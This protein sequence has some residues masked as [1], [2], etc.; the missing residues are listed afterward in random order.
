M[1][2]WKKGAKE[3]TVGINY[4]DKRGYQSSI[5]KPV[6]DALGNPDTIKFV[7]KGEKVELLKSKKGDKIAVLG[8]TR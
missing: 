5:P 8:G 2:K 4:Y 1:P 7:L 3:F 6:I